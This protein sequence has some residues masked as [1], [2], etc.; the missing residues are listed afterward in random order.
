M[1]PDF[2]VLQTYALPPGFEAGPLADNLL[3]YGRKDLAT[4]PGFLSGSAFLEL[5]RRTD[6][7]PRDHLLVLM[8]WRERPAYETYRASDLGRTSAVRLVA[9][10][11]HIAHYRGFAAVGDLDTA[12]GHHMLLRVPL[13]ARKGDELA[14]LFRDFV[15]Q[16]MGAAAGFLGSRV[17]VD[18]EGGELAVLFQ[19]RDLESYRTYRASEAG[20]EGARR[21]KS[22]S[23]SVWRLTMRG[24]SYG[25]T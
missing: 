3:E 20:E 23:P 13:G 9:L 24:I 2:F 18:E 8:H 5:Q 15:T 21:L 7:G 14:V 19:W 16:R 10:H 4:C 1:T 22:Y 17:L 25:L 11:P 6:D 12:A